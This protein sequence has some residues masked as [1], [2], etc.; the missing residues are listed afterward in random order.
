MTARS[1]FAWLRMTAFD[2][3]SVQSIRSVALSIGCYRALINGRTGLV[4]QCGGGNR[5]RLVGVR[6]GVPEQR[7]AFF[8]LGHTLDHHQSDISVRTSKG[9]VQEVDR[10]RS[11]ALDGSLN[12]VQLHVH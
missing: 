8:G 6:E 7:L 9:L 5:H 3:R 12:G 1:I 2:F 4:E 10:F 11:P